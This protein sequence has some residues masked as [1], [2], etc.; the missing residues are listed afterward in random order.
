MKT[1]TALVA[2]VVLLAGAGCSQKPQ[3]PELRPASRIVVTLPGI[4]DL[5]VP[6]I[7]TTT[8]IPASD[9]EIV[10]R[11]ITPERYYEGGV[12]DHIT[13]PIAVVVLTHSDQSESRLF[14]RWSGKNPALVSLD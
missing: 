10:T 6:A 9:M 4:P 14:I 5:I 13:P 11:L 8:E 7:P 2:V 1:R 3:A 12:N